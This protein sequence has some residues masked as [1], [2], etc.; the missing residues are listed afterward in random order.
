MRSALYW[1]TTLE[2]SQEEANAVGVGFKPTPT[3]TPH[4]P[5]RGGDCAKFKEVEQYQ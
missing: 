1:S 5:S 2:K 3:T 4:A